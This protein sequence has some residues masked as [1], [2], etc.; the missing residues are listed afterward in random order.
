MTIANATHEG[1][2]LGSEAP[3]WMNRQQAAQYLN[4]SPAWLASAD[5]RRLVPSFKFGNQ[6]RYSKTELERWAKAQ[7][8]A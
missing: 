4:V 5:G 3:E 2:S 8:A 1:R 7:R 6:V